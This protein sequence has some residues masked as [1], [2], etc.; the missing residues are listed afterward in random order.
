MKYQFRF[1][2]TIVPDGGPLSEQEKEARRHPSSFLCNKKR[3]LPARWE[4]SVI[5]LYNLEV[6]TGRNLMP[7]IYRKEYGQIRALILLIYNW[8]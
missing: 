8:I 6:V 4:R 2:K 5:S 1:G 3:P 7:M